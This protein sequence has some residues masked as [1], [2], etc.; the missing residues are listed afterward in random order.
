MFYASSLQLTV[1]KHKNLFTSSLSQFPI[2]CL[3]GTQILNNSTVLFLGNAKVL[4]R[5]N[6]N[7]IKQIITKGVT[8]IVLKKFNF[9]KYIYLHRQHCWQKIT[10]IHPDRHSRKNPE[11]WC[12][13]LWCL[14]HRYY[15]G[16]IHLCRPHNKDLKDK[17]DLWAY[18][19][20]AL[21]INFS[22]SMDRM[23]NTKNW[24]YL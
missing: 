20:L 23:L 5:S 10:G 11:C 3:A 4:F 19:L 9:V 6:F 15:Y 17:C 13:L 12:S 24:F 8:L 14:C 22:R 1:S 21:L 7:K 16:H 2:W 18:L